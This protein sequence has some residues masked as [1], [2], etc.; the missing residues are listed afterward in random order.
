MSFIAAGLRKLYV[1]F[2]KNILINFKFINEIL[3]IKTDLLF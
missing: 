1:R 3:T 2:N